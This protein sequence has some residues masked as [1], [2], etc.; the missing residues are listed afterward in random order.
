MSDK[1]LT[2]RQ[3]LLGIGGLVTVGFGSKGCSRDE[4]MTPPVD[5]A[6]GDDQAPPADLSPQDD[7]AAAREGLKAIDSVVV[8]MMENRSFDH[9]LGALKLDTMY[10]HALAVDGLTGTETN[11]APNGDPISA[12]KMSNFTPADPPH[13]W[14]ACH[15]QF[16]A[17]K[18]DGFVKAHAGASQNEVMGYHDRSQIPFYYWLADNFTICDQWHASVMGPTWPNRYYLHACSSGGKKDNTPYITGGP[19]TLWSRLKDAG[20]TGKNYRA[21]IVAWYTGGF[22]GQ[23]AMINPVV[24]IADFF[25]DAKNGTLPNFAIIDPDFQGPDD[26]PSHDI[27]KGQVFVAS[28][29][30]ALADSPQW[31]RTLFVITYDEHGGFYDHVPPPTTA[32]D[33]DEFK[34]LGFRVPSFVAGG[35]VKRGFVNK[36]LFEHSSVGATLAGAFGIQSLN[37]RMDAAN[38]LA[39]CLDPDLIKVPA[40]PPAGMPMPMMWWKNAVDQVGPWSQDELA[41]MIEK[42]MIPRSMIDTKTTQTLTRE[43]LAHAHR[44]GAVR[45][46]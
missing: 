23:S 37:Q 39:S 36:T 30:K 8:L 46:R 16:N 21:G 18:N 33:F 42:R 24:P 41:D 4:G 1:G 43:M 22:L 25:T 11:P 6:G 27:L 38:N 7:L 35:M 29:Y 20:K 9:Y 28:I 19:T 44:L 31:N 5:M 2:R 34:Q 32:D 12:F 3:A 40:P 17:G 15:N 13:G 26:H 45:M 14:A 10:A